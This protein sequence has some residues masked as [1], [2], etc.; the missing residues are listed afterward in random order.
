MD[1][2]SVVK[3]SLR[4][5]DDIP[6]YSAVNSL[7]LTFVTFVPFYSNPCLHRAG[8]PSGHI[9]KPVFVIVVPRRDSPFRVSG[10]NLASAAIL[11]KREELWRPQIIVAPRTHDLQEPVDCLKRPA[12]VSRQH[13]VA[14]DVGVFGDQVLPGATNSREIRISSSTYSLW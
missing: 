11:M 5:D 12:A 2:V 8:L 7:V 13:G 10:Q 1:S 6:I 9:R 3:I 4:T 14:V